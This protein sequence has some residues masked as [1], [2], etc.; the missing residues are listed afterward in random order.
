MKHKELLNE[1]AH[2]IAESIMGRPIKRR[3]RGARL[4]STASS[5]IATL[6]RK[7]QPP[8]SCQ[9]RSTESAQGLGPR[10]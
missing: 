2:N 10:S 8:P 6:N 5:R 4:G 7:N 9:T 3:V 1:W